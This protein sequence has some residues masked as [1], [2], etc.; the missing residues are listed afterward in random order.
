MQ[1]QSVAVSNAVT[2]GDSK[3]IAAHDGVS[4]IDAGANLLLT[5][6]TKDSLIVV[7]LGSTVQVT[8]HQH[9]SESG[10]AIQHLALT[11]QAGSVP[12]LLLSAA[13]GTA[14]ALELNAKPSSRWSLNTP[15]AIKSARIVDCAP[16]PRDTAAQSFLVR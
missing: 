10:A 13:D 15:A 2:N 7:Q 9:K 6:V 8:K 14:H 11:A 16:R 1:P 12:L 5:R 4:D 3:Y